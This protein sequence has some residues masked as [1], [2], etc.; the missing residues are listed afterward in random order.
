MGVGRGVVQLILS[1]PRCPSAQMGVGR[2]VLQLILSGPR[3]PSAQM[4]VGRG[5]VQLI[6][7]GPRCP[8]AQ[9]GVGRGVVQLILSGPRCPSAQ[10]GVG[11]G[12]VQLILSGPRCPSA[13]FEWAK[14]SFSSNRGGPRCR[15]AYFKWAEVSFRSFVAL[16]LFSYL[17]SFLFLS[18]LF[19]P[20]C[21][22]VSFIC[23]RLTC[24]YCCAI[25]GIAWA[26]TSTSFPAPIR[27]RN[28][29]F[30]VAFSTLLQASVIRFDYLSPCKNLWR[31]TLPFA[32]AQNCSIGLSSGE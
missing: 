24:F 18:L 30:E 14:V 1:G 29:A 12:V 9:M 28:K 2:G 17:F 19:L 22:V 31:F 5:V 27:M 8:S 3:C 13:H 16:S 6:L 15:S 25:V 4:G 21:V 32:T 11:R 7:S 20:H 23:L 26:F 10:M